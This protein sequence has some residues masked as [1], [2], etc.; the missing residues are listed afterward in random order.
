[1]SAA[2]QEVFEKPRTVVMSGLRNA[3]TKTIYGRKENI[4]RTGK[5]DSG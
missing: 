1:M 3:F 5:V 4:S 2:P